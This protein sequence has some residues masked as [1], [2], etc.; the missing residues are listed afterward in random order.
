[1]KKTVVEL[2]ATLSNI[3]QSDSYRKVTELKDVSSDIGIL[4]IFIDNPYTCSLKKCKPNG[5]KEVVQVY[6]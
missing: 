2:V 5:G 3:S 4:F 1:M 6:S